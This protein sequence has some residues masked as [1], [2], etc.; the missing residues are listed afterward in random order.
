[1]F[2]SGHAVAVTLVCVIFG[3]SKNTSKLKSV[4]MRTSNCKFVYFP[5]ALYV[6]LYWP[7]CILH[8]RNQINL[9]LMKL[10]I[11]ILFFLIEIAFRRQQLTA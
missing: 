9:I 6:I 5:N 1:M 4:K 3:A 11:F 7:T 2:S 8:Q 10:N